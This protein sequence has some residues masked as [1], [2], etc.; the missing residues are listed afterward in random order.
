MKCLYKIK[1]V[2]SFMFFCGFLVGFFNSVVHYLK[3]LGL[4]SL[5]YSFVIPL[6]DM[7]S[8]F[9]LFGVPHPAVF[10]LN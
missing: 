10:N 4:G 9:N 5:H 6:F 1:W 2:F 8:N 7:V 3:I